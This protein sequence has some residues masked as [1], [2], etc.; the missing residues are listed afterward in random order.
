MSDPLARYIEAATG[1]TKMTRDTAE[2]VVRSLVEQGQTAASDPQQLVEQLVERSQANRQALIGIVR[3]ETKRA[4]KRMGLATQADLE[5]LQRQVG[6]L[7]REVRGAETGGGAQERSAAGSDGDAG[8]G[9]EE[10]GS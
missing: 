7:R 5:R 3:S 4:V 6:D 10:G 8:T 1:L 2:K 9:T